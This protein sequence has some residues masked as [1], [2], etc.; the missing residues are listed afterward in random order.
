M[1]EA[2]LYEDGPW[3]EI[4]DAHNAKTAAKYGMERFYSQ[5]GWE[6]GNI[7]EFISVRKDGG[8]PTSFEVTAYWQPS[9]DVEPVEFEDDE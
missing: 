2:A 5:F 3:L 6:P 7:P 4:A 1:W 9:F 8:A